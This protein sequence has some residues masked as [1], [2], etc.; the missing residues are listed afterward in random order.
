[1]GQ[2]AAANILAALRNQPRTEFSYWDKGSMAT[3]GRSRAIAWIGG[4]QV[5]GFIA[6]LLWVFV[7]LL[8]LVGHRNRLVVMLTWAWQWLTWRRA[9]RLIW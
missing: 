5:G 9:M 4:L 1:M 2:H 6:W 8:F 7:H 3:I